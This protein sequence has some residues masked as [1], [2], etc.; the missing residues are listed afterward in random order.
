MP[1]VHFHGKGSLNVEKERERETCKRI[2]ARGGH[3]C[4]GRTRC[5][6]EAELVGI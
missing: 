1:E 4:G 6:D 2:R 5:N 3:G